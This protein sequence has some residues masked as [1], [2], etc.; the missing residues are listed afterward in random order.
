M[1]CI[2]PGEHGSTYGGNP[3]G[4]SVSLTALRVIQTENLCA[5]STHL[6]ELF[7]SSIREYM[8]AGERG[9]RLVKEVRGRGLFNAV[10][11][12]ETKSER[13]RT[14]WQFCLVLKSRGVL[15]KPTHRNMCVVSILRF[16]FFVRGL[17]LGL[18]GWVGGC[19]IRFSPPLVISEEDLKKAITIIKESLNDLDHVSTSSHR[20][21]YPFPY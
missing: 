21:I 5:R 6:G 4:C 19:S 3:L 16:Y 17:M 2:R 9:S 8:T 20:T 1:L 7:R 14:A 10:V 11:L 15:A 13:G 18:V 12:D